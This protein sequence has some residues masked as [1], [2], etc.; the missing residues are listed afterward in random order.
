[1]HLLALPMDSRINCSFMR[2]LSTRLL[3][4]LS[5]FSSP[6]YRILQF[7]LMTIVH[8]DSTIAT[9]VKQNKITSDCGLTHSPEV[10]MAV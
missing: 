5:T 2:C 1:M 9:T 6:E 8:G 10:M 7:S 3:A 4:S